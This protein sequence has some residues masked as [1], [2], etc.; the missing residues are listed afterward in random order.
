VTDGVYDALLLPALNYPERDRLEQRLSPDEETA[1]I[2][3]T[4]ELLWMRWS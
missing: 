2:D 3:A 1:V 4:R